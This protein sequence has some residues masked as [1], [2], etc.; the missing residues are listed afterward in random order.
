MKEAV[1]TQLTLLRHGQ[2]VGEEIFRGTT[3]CPL[4]PLGLEQMRRA[5]WRAGVNWDAIITS[6]ARRCREFARELAASLDRPLQLDAGLRELDFGDWEG[7][8]VA[9]VWQQDEQRLRAFHANPL[10]QGPPNGE[11][12]IQLAERVNDSLTALL[13]AYRGRNLLV[14]THGGVIRVL[15]SLWLDMPLAHAGRWEVPYACLTRLAA[16]HT[17]S[18]QHNTLIAHNLLKDPILDE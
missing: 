1:Q 3:D 9:E 13:Q 16:W 15:L 10:A 17:G 12:L 14:V 7:R 2:C 8:P 18:G 5:C 4:S 11:T 6:P